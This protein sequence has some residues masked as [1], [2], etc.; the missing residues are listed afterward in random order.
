MISQ[1]VTLETYTTRWNS[2]CYFW[3]LRGESTAIKLLAF[4]DLYDHV[5]AFEVHMGFQPQGLFVCSLEKR[6]I[7]LPS[8]LAPKL[9]TFCGRVNLPGFHEPNRG[10]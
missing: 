5:I 3:Y 8:C 10:L 9:R 2:S 7:M 4:F 6:G 1:P